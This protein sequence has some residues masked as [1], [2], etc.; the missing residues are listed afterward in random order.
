VNTSSDCLYC[1]FREQGSYEVDGFSTG[2]K[3]VAFDLETLDKQHHVMADTVPLCTGPDGWVYYFK[4][5]EGMAWY[6][7]NARGEEVKIG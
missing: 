5:S 3:I 2:E 4:Y 7:M 6:A 1:S